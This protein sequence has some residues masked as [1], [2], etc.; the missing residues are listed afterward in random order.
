MPGHFTLIEL[1]VVIAIIA[2]LAGMLLPALNKA[3]ERARAGACF[4]N[5]KGIVQASSLYSDTW[6]GW[7]VKSDPRGTGVRSGWRPLIAPFAGFT[8]PIYKAN[9]EFS[10]VMLEKISRVKGLFYCPSV[11]TP[12]DRWKEGTYAYEYNAKYNIYCYGMTNTQATESSYPEVKNRIPGKSW[13]NI[14]QLRGKGASDQLLFGDINDEGYYLADSGT[15]YTTQSYMLDIWPNTK[16]NY[17]HPSKRHSGGGNY[18]WLDG[19]VDFRKA[20]QLI[21]ISTSDDWKTGS[22]KYHYIYYWAL[23]P[24]APGT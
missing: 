2:I 1:L 3:R 4:G 10:A 13:T 22:G 21:G 11:K 9:G 12:Q 7:I 17:T 5:L 24:K 15:T 6:N 23:F 8:G 19:H 16:T 18:A 20:P 14:T